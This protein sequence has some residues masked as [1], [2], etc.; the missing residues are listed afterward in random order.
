MASIQLYSFDLCPYVERCRIVLAEKKIDFEQ[1]FIDLKAKPKGFASISPRGKVPVLV[2]GEAVVFESLIINE[3]LEELT[4]EP[5]MLPTTPLERGVV[6]AWAKFCDDEVMPHAARIMFEDSKPARRAAWVDLKIALRQVESWLESRAHEGPFFGGDR[7][8]LLDA[9]YAPILARL[10]F[11]EDRVEKEDT[12]ETMPLLS[13]C[14]TAHASATSVRAATAPDL[15]AQ[16]KVAYA[17]PI[18]LGLTP[19]EKERYRQALLRKGHEIAQKLAK[20]LGGLDLRLSDIQEMRDYGPPGMRP[21][22]RLRMYLDLINNK[23]KALEANDPSFD[24]EGID[25]IVR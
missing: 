10:A 25:H 3:F 5:A 9:T 24:L 19:E 18:P 11:F 22:E 23:R 1:T 7:L 14:R 15:T 20:V 13:A 6:R 4:P 12:L 16:L 21:E 2:I 17:P 8:N